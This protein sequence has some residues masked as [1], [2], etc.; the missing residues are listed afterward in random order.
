MPPGEGLSSNFYQ[1]V[2]P[3]GHSGAAGAALVARI[4]SDRILQHPVT[5]RAEPIGV[6]TLRGP[7]ARA[8]SARPQGARFRCSRARPGSISAALSGYQLLT[9]R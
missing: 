1:R 9:P 6:L 3:R 2:E 5:G 8:G 7:L 4:A